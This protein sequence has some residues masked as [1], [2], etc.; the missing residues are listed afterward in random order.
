MSLILYQE[1]SISKTTN[2][3]LDNSQD[4]F[5]CQMHTGQLQELKENFK[6]SVFTS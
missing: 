5:E 6:N 3:P 1:I 4:C 2:F